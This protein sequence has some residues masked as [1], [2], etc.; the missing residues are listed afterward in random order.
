VPVHTVLGSDAQLVCPRCGAVASSFLAGEADDYRRAILA[1]C[2]HRIWTNNLERHLV[3]EGSLVPVVLR[4][5]GLDVA[6]AYCNTRARACQR[7]ATRLRAGLA[8]C[9]CG[10]PVGDGPDNCAIP[11]WPAELFEEWADW[12]VAAALAHWAEELLDDQRPPGGGAGPVVTTGTVVLGV[13]SQLDP[14]EN[15]GRR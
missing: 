15:G 5:Q 2:G 11:D 1:P 10:R 13:V 3:G 9:D 8:G 7:A 6:L 12:W 14:G 4:G